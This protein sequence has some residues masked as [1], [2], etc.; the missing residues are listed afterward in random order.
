MI[1]SNVHLK[2]GM[3]IEVHSSGRV[4]TIDKASNNPVSGMCTTTTI[5]GEEVISKQMSTDYLKKQL[6][7]G[8]MKIL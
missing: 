3:R 5:V 4:F 8:F 1:L 2:K 6:C 7:F